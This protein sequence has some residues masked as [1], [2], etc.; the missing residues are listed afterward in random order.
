MAT[1][2]NSPFSM[3]LQYHLALIG[4]GIYMEYII[5]Y[6]VEPL[7]YG[8]R[9]LPA[10]SLK[11]WR[12]P[13]GCFDLCDAS[14][15]CSLLHW[16][17][18]SLAGNRYRYNPIEPPMFQLRLLSP[19]EIQAEILGEF[20]L[21]DDYNPNGT[22]RVPDNLYCLQWCFDPYFF[23][24]DDSGLENS[25]PLIIHQWVTIQQLAEW[26]SELEVELKRELKRL[27]K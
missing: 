20:R 8:R 23:K 11:R 17:E 9:F 2:H 14:D 18:K 26:K 25:A 19:A 7:L 27:G 10:D 16:L 1:L 24:A 22:G 13:P 5:H 12:Q 3:R 4:S 21:M 6:W 15:Q